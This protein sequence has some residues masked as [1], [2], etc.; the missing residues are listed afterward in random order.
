MN[1]GNSGNVIVLTVITIDDLFIMRSNILR[2]T[3]TNVICRGHYNLYAH[4]GKKFQINLNGL[5]FCLSGERKTRGCGNG[6]ENTGEAS[7]RYK[8]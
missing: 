8:E 3:Q 7:G 2:K 6:Y 4:Q 5:K 1:T